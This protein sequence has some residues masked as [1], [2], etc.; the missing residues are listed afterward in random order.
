MGKRT[1]SGPKDGVASRKRARVANALRTGGDAL[2]LGGHKERRRQRRQDERRQRKAGKHANQV[3]RKRE[4]SGKKLLSEDQLESMVDKQLARRKKLEESLTRESES[5]RLAQKL[6]MYLQQLEANIKKDEGELVCWYPGKAEHL[7][8]REQDKVKYDPNKLTGACRPAEEAYPW[9]YPDYHAK[10]QRE[11]REEEEREQNKGDNILKMFDGHWGKHYR[12]RELAGRYLELALRMVQAEE[13]LL[14]DALGKNK[15]KRKINECLQKLQEMDKDSATGLWLPWLGVARAIDDGE[16]A[17]A[18]EL[19]NKTLLK[20]DE[21]VGEREPMENMLLFD[22]ALIEFISAFVL[23]EEGSSE[24]EALKVVDR[25]VK[26]NPCIARCLAL[27][28]AY[29][30]VVDGSETDE[31]IATQLEN[32][33]KNFISSKEELPILKQP[34]W[35][36]EEQA[37]L[38][39]TRSISWWRDSDPCF[40]NMLFDALQRFGDLG[41]STCE[42]D[43]TLSR[44]YETVDDDAFQMLNEGSEDE[45]GEGEEQDEDVNSDNEEA[46]AENELEASIKK[47]LTDRKFANAKGIEEDDD[48]EEEDEEEEEEEEREAPE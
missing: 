18:R 21:V 25:A 28:D 29:E 32:L 16:L 26:A 11:E 38:Y 12:T 15:P 10:K 4:A 14:Q 47:K 22:L 9:L 40:A 27:H 48:E 37:V 35:S 31:V 8:K 3:Q 24:E 42:K 5:R 7:K 33:L 13:S 46:L 34:D 2:A 20:E 39:F 45:E 17:K 36:Q 30:E 1:R 6:Q 23:E 43:S 19:I 44:M 41:K